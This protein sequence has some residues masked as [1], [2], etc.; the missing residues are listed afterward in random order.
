M[1]VAVR[2]VSVV[3]VPLNKVIRMA[4][5]GNR[6]VATPSAVPMAAFMAVTSVRFRAIVWIG[7]GSFDGVLVYVALVLMVQMTVVQV[8]DVSGVPD[9]RVRAIG[10]MLVRVLAMRC[11]FHADS[12]QYV[13]GSSQRYASHSHLAVRELSAA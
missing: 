10:T 7:A 1:V 8:V 3:K 13:R 2:V 12:V 5:V 6:F 9:L 11:M 4:G